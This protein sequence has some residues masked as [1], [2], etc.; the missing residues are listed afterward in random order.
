MITF[1]TRVEMIQA[2]SG[3]INRCVLLGA[4]LTVHHI[5]LLFLD[6]LVQRRVFGHSPHP[7]QNKGLSEGLSRQRAPALHRQDP[8]NEAQ[9][10][11]EAVMMVLVEPEGRV[12][13]TEAGGNGETYEGLEGDTER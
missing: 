11:T 10:E 13:Q 1:W 4:I 7:W 2:N 3:L 6:V 9:T 12:T 5:V 8:V